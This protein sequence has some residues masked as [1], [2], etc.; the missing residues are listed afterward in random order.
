MTEVVDL[1]VIG[2][3]SSPKGIFREKALLFSLCLI[4]LCFAL[5]AFVCRL[6]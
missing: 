6:H 5:P 2:L 4:L 1:S 3:T